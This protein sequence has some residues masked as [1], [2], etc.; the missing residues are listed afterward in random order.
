MKEPKGIAFFNIKTGDTHYCRLEPTIQAYINSSDMGIN[1]SRG[2]D[3][4]WRLDKEWVK[5]V[6]EFRKDNTKMAN[7]SA[8]LRLGEEESPNLIQILYAIY[9]EQ[10]RTARI[11]SQEHES[12]YEQEY[13]ESI[14]N[15]GVDSAN[16]SESTVDRAESVTESSQEEF[17]ASGS[18]KSVDTEQ[19]S[20][21]KV[22]KS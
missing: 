9:G 19:K 21:R 17:A 5:K 7:L 20:N 18:D 12:P 8:K 15:K 13:L 4:G 6:R 2:Q 22:K 10:L 1:A 14:S 11:E 3:F 16:S